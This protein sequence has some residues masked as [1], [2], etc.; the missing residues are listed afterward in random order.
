MA[1]YK[2]GT[3]VNENLEIS[4]AKIPTNL[5]DHYLRMSILRLQ[6]WLEENVLCNPTDGHHYKKKIEHGVVYNEETLKHFVHSFQ[7]WFEELNKRKVEE[8]KRTG[9]ANI[10]SS[11]LF[12]TTSK[13]TGQGCNQTV[14]IGSSL[15]PPISPT[16]P[17]SSP[18]GLSMMGINLSRRRS[19]K[20]LQSP[21]SPR[22]L[23]V[24]EPQLMNK[25]PESLPS[26]PFIP[27][28]KPV[29][30]IDFSNSD[31]SRDDSDDRS[32]TDQEM[33]ALMASSR[34]RRKV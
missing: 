7:F 24:L 12:N 16:L 29:K 33:A 11:N 28:I 19:S 15:S 1:N 17:S 9:G 26:A 30:V 14:E 23:N 32:P 13:S 25:D 31:N 18:P 6:M 4:V 2:M 27:K 5:Y 22:L 20:S 3:Y 34:G 21:G 10:V 8:D